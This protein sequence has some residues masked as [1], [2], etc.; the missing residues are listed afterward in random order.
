MGYVAPPT[1]PQL[2][3]LGGG[4]GRSGSKRDPVAQ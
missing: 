1:L 2:V 4:C 3:G